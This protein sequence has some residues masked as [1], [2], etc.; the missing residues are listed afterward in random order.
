MNVTHCLPNKS[1]VALAS[2]D[3]TLDNYNDFAKLIGKANG[4]VSGDVPFSLQVNDLFTKKV[5]Q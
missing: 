4:A 2:L 3:F 5:G 1:S